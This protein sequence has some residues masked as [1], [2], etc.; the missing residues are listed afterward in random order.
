MASA[1]DRALWRYADALNAVIISKDE[2]FAILRTLE[3]SGPS[4]LWLRC[5]NVTRRALLEWIEPL[6]PA[7]L[8]ALDRGEMLIELV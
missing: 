5:G 6:F 1:D 3:S 2:D 8:D 4:V 7:A